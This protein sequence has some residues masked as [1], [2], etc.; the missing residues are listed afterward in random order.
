MGVGERKSKGVPDF[1]S[2]YEVG[3]YGRVFVGVYLHYVRVYI[4][5]AFAAQIEE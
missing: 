5:V 1:P 3:F 4:A 2:R